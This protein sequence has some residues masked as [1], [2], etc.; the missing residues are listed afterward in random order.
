[1]VNA[2]KK[3]GGDVKFTVYPEANHDS[4]T[5]TYNNPELYKWF[6]EHKK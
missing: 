1:M 2:L 6:L 4:W 5:E 3:S